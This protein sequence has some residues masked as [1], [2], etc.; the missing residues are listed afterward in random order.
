MK[1]L[2]V[3]IDEKGD[4]LNI[5]KAILASGVNA[6]R[7]LI[8]RLLDSGGI[9]VNGKQVRMASRKVRRGDL[10]TLSFH[11]ETKA[12][13]PPSLSP[14]DILFRQDDL[15]AINKAPLV[16]STPTRS[17]KSPHAKGLLAPLLA[18]MN[19]ASEHLSVCHRLDKE[20]SGVLLFALSQMRADWIMR[21]FRER[22][23][24]K[25]YY[26]IV[27]GKPKHKKWELRCFLSGIDKA[28]G[29]VKPVKSGGYDSLT[30]FERV[31]SDERHNVSLIRAL[32]ETGRSHQIRVH[33]LMSGF[34]IVGDKRYYLDKQPVLPP[35]LHE[36][37][38]KHHFLH[39]YSLTFQPTDGV[40]PVTVTADA[41]ELFVHFL[42]KTEMP[43]SRLTFLRNS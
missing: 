37:T 24:R 33:L 12:S 22:K 17:E 29:S 8:R 13:K 42:E 32:P 26:A 9:K 38:F 25:V 28:T 20:T 15:I 5:D 41:P 34:P 23:V 36:L 16:S 7:R 21:Q 31:A 6:S 2:N 43:L 27:Y 4:G 40:N 3:N 19:L 18:S 35:A 30:R 39:A 10:I 11:E 14:R 1:Q